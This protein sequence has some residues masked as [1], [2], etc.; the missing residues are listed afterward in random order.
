MRGPPGV[1]CAPPSRLAVGIERR[2]R[3]ES[4]EGLRRIHVR[5][6]GRRLPRISSLPESINHLSAHHTR[7]SR[8]RCAPIHSPVRT[9]AGARSR[10]LRCDDHLHEFALCRN[11]RHADGRPGRR[12]RT[13]DQPKLPMADWGHPITLRI[14]ELRVRGKPSKAARDAVRG[15]ANGVG[16]R[17]SERGIER[18]K[19]GRQTLPL[20][21]RIS[22][23][24]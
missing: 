11:A 1:R 12:H 16:R 10:L 6:A 15:Q 22:K 21:G 5:V 19:R 9:C 2:K 13:L 23:S 3:L 18:P 14:V 8:R 24:G 4:G 17:E 7:T 20:S